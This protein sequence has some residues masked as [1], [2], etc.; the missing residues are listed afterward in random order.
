MPKL[1]DG[2][3]LLDNIA[4]ASIGFIEQFSAKGIC[5]LVWAHAKLNVSH[6]LLFQSVGGAVVGMD[7]LEN[8]RPENLSNLVWAYAR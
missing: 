1:N 5:N 3:M 2:G 7:T 6:H 4:E 8:F